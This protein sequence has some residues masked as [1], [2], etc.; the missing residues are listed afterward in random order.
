MSSPRCLSTFK[1]THHMLRVSP[2]NDPTSSESSHLSFDPTTTRT[3]VSHKRLKIGAVAEIPCTEQG[4]LGIVW[5]LGRRYKHSVTINILPDNVFLDIFEFC[6]RN[7]HKSPFHRMWEWQRLVHVCRRWRHII[8][9]SPRRLDLHLFCTY[10]TSVR[11]NLNCWPA[12]P[13]I[14]DYY[15]YWD[16]DSGQSLAPDNDDNVVAALEYPDRVRCVEIAA[17]GS[18]L[19]KVARV[20][21]EPFPALTLLRLSSNDGD[22]P[23]LPSAFLG[24]SAPRLQEICL[25]GIPFLTLPT[26]L[27][28]TSDLVVLKLDNIPDTG[29]ISS[30]EMVTCLSALTK[31]RTLSIGFRLPTSHSDQTISRPDPQARAVLPA[32][33]FFDFRGTSEYLENLVAQIDTP[34]LDYFRITY[35]NRFTIDIPQL[36]QFISRTES[37]ELDRS[38]HAELNFGVGKANIRLDCEHVGRRQSRLFLQISCQGLDRQVLLLSQVLGQSPAM[39]SNVGHL[40]IHAHCLQLAWEE[41]EEEDVGDVGYLELLRPFAAVETLRLHGH[42][43]G[44][45]ALALEVVAEEMADAEVLPVLHSLWLQDLP[46]ASLEHFTSVR[47]KYGCPVAIV[48]TEREFLN[49]CGSHHRT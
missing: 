30:E 16:P 29:Y 8:F 28:S 47:W 13:I 38:K 39:L 48:N 40:S 18:L 24:G 11:N 41:D 25:D 26:L 31:L 45:V 19:G 43:A 2:S 6:L 32:L 46:V 27:L 4:K 36:S 7:P 23:V 34:L 3:H 22:V 21:Q 17:T 12:F 37:L 15:P 42:A 14:V 5:D 35:F 20:M 9:A 49:R 44:P 33:A 1:T 10:G